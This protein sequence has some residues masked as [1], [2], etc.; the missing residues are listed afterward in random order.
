MVFA[1]VQVNGTIGI[2]FG[3]AYERQQEIVREMQPRIQNLPIGSTVLLD[4]M[5]RWHGPSPVFETSW[6]TT[7]RLKL[8]TGDATIQGD[9]VWSDIEVHSDGVILPGFTSDP[10]LYEFASL[11]VY[12]VDTTSI[13]RLESADKARSYF[14]KDSPNALHPCAGYPGQGEPVFPNL[15]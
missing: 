13:I 15:F 5:C 6:D 11:Y 4:G 1:C 2:L 7:G 9:V 14:T 8:L 3:E 10:H 12:R